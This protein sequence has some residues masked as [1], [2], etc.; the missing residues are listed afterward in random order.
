MINNNNSIADVCYFNKMPG[1][2]FLKTNFMVARLGAL[3]S[4]PLI[5][6]GSEVPLGYFTCV[7]CKNIALPF[8]FPS[9]KCDYCYDQKSDWLPSEEEDKNGLYGGNSSVGDCVSDEQPGDEEE[10]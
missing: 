5:L 9:R 4:G 8:G 7:E 6:N 2:S 3:L 1:F 10:P